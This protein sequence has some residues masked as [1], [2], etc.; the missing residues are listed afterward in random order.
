M[1]WILVTAGPGGGPPA[2]AVPQFWGFDAFR[3]AKSAGLSSVS[4]V[5][6]LLRSKALSPV[7]VGIVRPVP[8]LQ[9]LPPALPTWSTVAPPESS[10]RTPPLSAMPVE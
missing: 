9:G 3:P 5:P 1:S 4:V 2:Q 10:S 7:A 6:P 8:S